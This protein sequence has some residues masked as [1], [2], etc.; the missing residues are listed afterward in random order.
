LRFL[1]SHGAL[2]VVLLWQV[3]FALIGTLSGG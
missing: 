3:R 1:I 2:P